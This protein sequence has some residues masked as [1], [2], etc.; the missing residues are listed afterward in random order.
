MD[1]NSFS[2]SLKAISLSIGRYQTSINVAENALAQAKKN[3]DFILEIL[4]ELNVKISPH[5]PEADKINQSNNK[6][7]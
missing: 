4:N 1:R 3:R 6:G 5:L 2:H 7:E